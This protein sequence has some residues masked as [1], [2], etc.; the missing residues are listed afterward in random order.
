M[1]L[2]ILIRGLPCSGKSTLANCIANSFI[3]VDVSHFEADMFFVDPKGN[4]NFDTSRL[5]E[6]HRYCQKSVE[7][8]MKRG[9]E[10][11]IVSNTFTQKKEADYY[12]Y[13]ATKYGYNTQI[14]TSQ[15]NWVCKNEHDVPKKTCAAMR[16]RFQDSQGWLD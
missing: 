11:I 13:M 1:K 10:C 5:S 9:A 16:D 3:D 12:L 4:Y 15:A 14:I 7:N 2:L 8:E 6:A